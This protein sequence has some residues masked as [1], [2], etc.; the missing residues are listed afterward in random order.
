MGEVG[1][2]HITDRLADHK[3]ELV[4]RQLVKAEDALDAIKQGYAMKRTALRG[5]RFQQWRIR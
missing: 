2:Q 4:I 1:F 5:V 3:I